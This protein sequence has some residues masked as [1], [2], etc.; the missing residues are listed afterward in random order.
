MESNSPEWHSESAFYFRWELRKHWEHWRTRT[1]K[2]KTDKQQQLL[3]E[4]QWFYRIPKARKHQEKNSVWHKCMETISYFSWRRKKYW[5][6]TC[7]RSQSS[8]VSEFFIEIKKKDGDQYEPTTLTFHRSLQRYLNDHRSTL[9]ILKDQQFSLSRE[10]LSSRKRQLLR[11]FGKGN[12]C[13]K[14]LVPCQTQKRTVDVW[15]RRIWRPRSCKELSVT[16]LRVPSTRW[17]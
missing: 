15:T 10:A 8:Y 3:A 12:R 1:V 7:K 6:H 5:R 13:H 17:E 2:E 9:N 4:V 14:P 11:D 16:P